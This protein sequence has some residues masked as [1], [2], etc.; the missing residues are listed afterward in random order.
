M[1]IVDIPIGQL[2]TA[3]RRGRARSP[4]TLALIEAIESLES[5]TAK[6]LVLERGEDATKLRAKLMYAAKIVGRRLR[7]AV[8]DDRVLFTR[9]PGRPRSRA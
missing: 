5:G 2:R 9:G 8:E 4:E 1:K 3:R 6:A 7:V